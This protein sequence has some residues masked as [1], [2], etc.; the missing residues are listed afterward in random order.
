MLDLLKK[1]S[2]GCE[3]AR[4][5]LYQHL[6]ADPRIK[7]TI[8]SL[9][10]N[11]SIIEPEDIRAEFWLGVMKGLGIVKN[12]CG[13]PIMHL[14]KRGVWQVQ[15]IVRKELRAKI[16]Q[17]CIKCGNTNKNYSYKRKCEYCSNDV[18][19]ESRY[20]DIGL[21]DFSIDYLSSIGSN[22]TIMLASK[23]SPNQLHILELLIQACLDGAE[24]PIVEVAR[25]VNISRE[26]VRQIVEIIKPKLHIE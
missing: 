3:N 5:Q 21:H 6:N 13:D 19:H 7:R 17:V 2:Q 1:A 10:Y 16:M 22:T 18:T 14:I 20:E 25:I 12:E 4:N 11:K 15:S 9:S 26:R 24:H 23:I 8:R